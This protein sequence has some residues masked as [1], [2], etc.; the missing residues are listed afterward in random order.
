MEQQRPLL[1]ISV[2]DPAGIELGRSART[3]A[4][5]RVVW[6]SPRSDGC[7]AGIAYGWPSGPRG[8]AK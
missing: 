3:R 6:V 5:G 1:G 8:V 2:G 4:P 7:I